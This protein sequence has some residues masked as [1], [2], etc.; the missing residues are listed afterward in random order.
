MI[1]KMAVSIIVMTM[2]TTVLLLLVFQFVS[3]S[4]FGEGNEQDD[5]IITHSFHNEDYYY[6]LTDEQVNEAIEQGK[7]SLTTLEGYQLPKL[8]ST[9]ESQDIAFVYINT[10]YLKTKLLA[11]DTYD[12]YGRT[13]RPQEVKLELMDK[14]LSFSS[15]FQGNKGYIYEIEMVQDGEMIDPVEV[16]VSGNGTLKTVYFEVDEISFTKNAQLMISDRLDDSKYESY[17]ID[18]TQYK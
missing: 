9:I 3:P 18:F 15:R 14:F 5:D 11:R 8:D 16:T 7:E 6:Y 17:E 10:P 4:T 12:Q 2:F 13:M 1:K